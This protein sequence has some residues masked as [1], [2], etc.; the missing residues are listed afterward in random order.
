[1]TGEHGSNGP[2]M[3]CVFFAAGSSA[4]ALRNP[5]EDNRQR[6]MRYLELY[7]SDLDNVLSRMQDSHATH[8]LLA[9][10]A[11]VLAESKVPRPA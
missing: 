6:V 5:V 9:R 8:G 1:M 10:F 2:N 11:D 7:V 4:L 3:L